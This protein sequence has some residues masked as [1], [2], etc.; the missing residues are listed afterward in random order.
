M[1]PQFEGIPADATQ[2]VL[3]LGGNDAL[4]NFDM[5]GAP[6]T[7]SGAA[8]VLFGQRLDSFETS[9]RRELESLARRGTPLTVCT[10]YNGALP[11]KADR[12][13]RVALMMFND[14]I[15]RTAASVRASVIELRAICTDP[16]DY[17]NP[18]EP[19][20]PGGLKIAGA[21]ARA[22]GALPGEAASRVFTG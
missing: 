22:V 13:T 16:A 18:I 5:L 6:V 14:V 12:L 9:Y 3:S 10:I 20:G 17:A 19:S 8:V 21:I 11:P 7:S 15:V 1:S 4:Q 2:L